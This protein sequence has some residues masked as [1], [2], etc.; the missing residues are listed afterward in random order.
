MQ[1][2]RDIIRFRH[3]AVPRSTRT[4]ALQA[5]LT[6]RTVLVGDQGYDRNIALCRR[7][8]CRGLGPLFNNQS[9]CIQIVEIKI[10]FFLA[11][12]RVQ[13]RRRRAAANGNECRR[14]F[15][16][17]GQHNGDAVVAPNTQF[18]ESRH[19]R[20]SQRPQPSVIEHTAVGCAD[21]RR[22]FRTS[23]QQV[24]DRLEVCHVPISRF[25]GAVLR[26]GFDS[27]AMQYGFS[28]SARLL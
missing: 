18:V 19:R 24:S 20:V 21:R 28:V 22:I 15:R 9:F 10:K 12:S 6:G 25:S 1:D 16:A 23:I 3:T 2:K 26:L 4:F 13:G 14:H 8:D 27:A 5:E 17:I 7:R 11:V